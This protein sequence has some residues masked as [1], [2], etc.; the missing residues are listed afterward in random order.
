MVTPTIQADREERGTLAPQ[1]LLVSRL[2]KPQAAAA[3]ARLA[4]DRE[5]RVDKAIFSK[6]PVLREPVAPEVA[7]TEL[8]AA[9]A[10]DLAEP[11]VVRVARMAA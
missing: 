10:P 2:I 11:E 9:L 3:A 6:V 1:A 8:T 4:V 5:E 7:P